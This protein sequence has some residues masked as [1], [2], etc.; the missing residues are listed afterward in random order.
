MTA[1]PPQGMTAG[2][3]QVHP[4]P[5]P[6]GP[7]VAPPFAA[8]PL[9][10][11]RRSLWIGLI[12]GGVA[13]VLCCAGGLFGFGLLVVAGNDQTQMQA[14]RTVQT[15]V[16]AVHDENYAK[17]RSLLCTDLLRHTSTQALRNEWGQHQI[18]RYEISPGDISGQNATVTAT[19][20]YTD[21][22]P[23]TY[24]FTLVPEGTSW[25]ICG[26]Q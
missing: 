22:A 13:F 18:S 4:Y 2:Q 16:V 15:F 11:S 14:Q 12:V 23:R 21:Q 19:L 3:Q 25:K 26:W 7:G 6:P 5:P 17:A 24:T 10:R 8:P 9:D 20:D 1:G